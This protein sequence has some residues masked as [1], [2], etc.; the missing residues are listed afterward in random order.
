MCIAT[1]ADASDLMKGRATPA[2][3]KVSRNAHEKPAA[4]PSSVE[5]ERIAALR[6][7]EDLV[8]APGEAPRFE[9]DAIEAFHTR[10][11][12]DICLDSGPGLGLGRRLDRLMGPATQTFAL[13]ASGLHQSGAPNP[14]N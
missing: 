1:A 11:S 14:A 8:T 3:V 4:I 7:E 10:H 13:F 2:V 5:L 6:H 9:W 12:R